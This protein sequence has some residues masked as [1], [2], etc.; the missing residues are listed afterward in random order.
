MPVVRGKKY[1][2]TKR[3]VAAAKKAASRLKTATGKSARKWM[4]ATA[5]SPV[6]PAGQYLGPMRTTGFT[7]GRKPK[8]TTKKTKP[9]RKAGASWRDTLRQTL[10][11]VAGAPFPVRMVSAPKRSPRAKARYH[12]GKGYKRTFAAPGP[13]GRR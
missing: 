2:Y 10:L 6:A 8:P 3:G 13:R 7:T 5:Q 4:E 11:T 9:A 12:A 1:S